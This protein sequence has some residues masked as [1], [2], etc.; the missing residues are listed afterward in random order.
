LRPQHAHLRAE[1]WTDAHPEVERAL[2]AKGQAQRLGSNPSHGFVQAY[3]GFSVLDNVEDHPPSTGL[4]V[5]GR[6]SDQRT[7]KAASAS[8][9][10]D[11]QAPQ[12]RKVLGTCT[13]T[14]NER[15]RRDHRMLGIYLNDHLAGATAGLA[16]ARRVVGSHEGSPAEPELAELA[17]EVEA[18]RGTLIAIMARLRVRRDPVR[19]TIAMVG[20]R[21]GRLKLNGSLLRRSPL[22]ILVELEMMS[23]GVEGKQAG[24]YWVRQLRGLWRRRASHREEVGAQVAQSWL[25]LEGLRQRSR[26]LDQSRFM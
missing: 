25:R 17:R 16:L 11:K 26:S 15:P 8:G 24:W 14:A 10:R 12:N 19:A 18:D 13:V 2:V 1:R 9:R 7:P 6:S 4:G 5:V 3:S 23:L 21:A 22:S 20:E